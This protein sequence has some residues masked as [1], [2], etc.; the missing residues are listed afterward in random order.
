M[1]IV[2]PSGALVGVGVFMTTLLLAAGRRLFARQDTAQ[3]SPVGGKKCDDRT[4]RRKGGGEGE[5]E[6]DGSDD[7]GGGEMAND[8]NED[9]DE[10]SDEQ[11]DEQEE[12]VA[13]AHA[14]KKKSPLSPSLLAKLGKKTPPPSPPLLAKLVKKTPPRSPSL[15][16]KPMKPVSNAQQLANRAA[17]PRT[18]KKTAKSGVNQKTYQ[19][20]QR[21]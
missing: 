13:A 14:K 12:A 2:V 7:E 10:D 18:N 15:L 3:R 11:E 4:A 20:L 19:P 9:K 16:A 17:S 8:E 6:A 1:R 5:G 21:K